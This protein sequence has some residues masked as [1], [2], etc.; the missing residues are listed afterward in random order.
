MVFRHSPAIKAGLT[1]RTPNL[2]RLETNRHRLRSF[3]AGHTEGPWLLNF[4]GIRV[5]HC[6]DR[7]ICGVSGFEHNFFDLRQAG[8][9]IGRIGESLYDGR[10]GFKGERSPEDL[11][12]WRAPLSDSQSVREINGGA[13]LRLNLHTPLTTRPSSRRSPPTA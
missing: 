4:E 7:F 9:D 1:T 5:S 10:T 12:C 6:G 3:R 11:S 13:S 2:L 8:V